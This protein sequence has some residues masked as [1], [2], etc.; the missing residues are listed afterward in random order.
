MN[1][2]LGLAR[3]DLACYAIAMFQRLELP[4]HLRVL[5]GLLE[6]VERGDLKRLMVC[7]PPRHGKS[8]ITTT[9]FPAW[10]L[11]RHPDRQLISA[12]YAQELA[13]DFGRKVR[14]FVADPRHRAIFPECRLSEDST[15]AHRFATTSG[16]VYFA[17]GRGGPITGRG[18][19]LLLIDDPLKDREEASSATMRRQLQQWY[20]EVAY[21][22]LQPGGAVVIIS[23]RWHEDDLSGWLLRERAAENWKLL[24]LPALAEPGDV[25]GRGEGGAL[26]PDRFP[27]R[28]LEQTKIQLGSGAFAALYQ[29]RPVALEG[30]I[31][32]R[33]WWRFYR[34]APAFRRII[35][36]L[37]CAFKTGSENDF[38]AA[39]VWGEA[40]N[41]YYLLD[42][43]RGR[44]EF[45]DLKRTVVSL[46]ERWNP[47][48]VLI[49]DK[50]SGQSLVQELRRETTLAVKPI[51]AERDKVTRAHAVT[52]IVEGAKVY[53]PD[54]APWLGDYLD[55]LCSFPSAPHDDLTDCT[56]QAL[57]YLSQR[58]GCGL[59]APPTRPMSD[60]RSATDP[61][62]RAEMVEL[63]D[64]YQVSLGPR[65][66]G[67][68]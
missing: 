18:A 21:T 4:N 51:K 2:L 20:A 29:Q 59:S 7:M 15:A 64:G 1:D 28:Y 17:V 10:Y 24:S 45:P 57:A 40:A 25:L 12:S 62:R 65:R 26:W 55:E 37:D 53:L 66:S 34:Q 44:V 41:G 48:V 49:E 8:L 56:V 38:S 3:R 9:L 50:A 47:H 39:S 61:Y 52:A 33:E 14:N 13:D 46:A 22:R 58:V 68:W 11:G 27:A 19:D 16:G 67:A 36:S 23:T 32:K 35:L 6:E 31:F 30:A 60:S 54:T 43:W 5:L 42:V 63:P